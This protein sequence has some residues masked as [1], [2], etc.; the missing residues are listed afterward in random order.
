M[1]L[2]RYERYKDSGV[3]WLGGV[4]EHWDIYRSRR[5][6]AQRKERVRDSD[7]Q[8]TA[9]QKHGIVTQEAFMQAEGRAVVRVIH[10]A[11]IL[12]HVEPDDFVISMRS[13]QGG[14]EWSGIRGCISSAYVMLA[15]VDSVYPG[16][17]RYLFKSDLY[18]QALQTTSNLVRDGQAMRYEKFT[19]I[20][21]PL[22]PMEEQRNV[23]SFLD[24]ETKKI[25]ELIEEQ[26]R[27][28]ELLKEKRQAVI[29]HAVTKGL[30]PNAPT[31]DSNI[32][33]VGHFPY[34]W[35]TSYVKRI[36]SIRYGI[37]E[38][39]VYRDS[40]TPLI[41]ATN[42]HAGKLYEDDLVLIDPSDI[43]GD[44]AFW[45]EPGDIIVVRSGAYTGDSAIIRK[46]YGPCIAGFDMILRCVDVNPY[47]VQYALLSS[48]LKENQIDLERTRAA[49]PHLNAQELGS[50]LLIIPTPDEQE[51]IVEYLDQ[52][53]G[54]I[55][56]LIEMA[57]DGTRLLQERRSA[58]ISSAVTGK[59]DVRNFTPKEAA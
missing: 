59:I 31:K 4:P 9:S 26:R 54:A 33:G 52:V 48:Y 38:P 56:R 23:A 7:E 3:D 5:L 10:G 41:R 44:R 12:K 27:L 2:P 53:T 32:G 50:M 21:L 34:E 22:P 40:G 58:L 14:L 36:G 13:F 18:I 20:D 57:E 55:D 17:F 35:S 11:E 30:D 24:H 15:P 25:E 51:A 16:F 45:L 19:L 47:F 43:P 8:L 6:F 49:Q 1:S 42:V 39:P 29:S 37:G 28:I 46:G